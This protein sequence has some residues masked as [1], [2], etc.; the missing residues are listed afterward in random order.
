MK[1]DFFAAIGIFVRVV[2]SGSFTAAARQVNGSTAQISRAV[3][4]LERQLG[5]RLLNRTTRHI[6]MTES[7]ERYFK[8]AKTILADIEHA[9]AEA[10]NRL[11]KPYGKLR[12]HAMPSLGLRYLTSAMVQYQVSNPDVKIELTLSERFPNLIEDG[13]DVSLMATA[14]LPTSSYVSKAL[15]GNYSVLVASPDYVQRSGMPSTVTDLA[16]H[17]CLTLNAPNSAPEKWRLHGPDG[18]H[19]HLVQASPF[20]VNMPDAMRF[21]LLAGA[22]IGP[23]TLHSAIDDLRRGTLVRVLPEYRVNALTVYALYTSKRYLD[24]K[25]S[26]F[27]QHLHGI[28][29]PAFEPL[30]TLVA[31][32]R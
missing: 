29:L 3:A 17:S 28:A 32:N 25:V 16:A 30:D 24:A 15:G 31:A 12:V 10:R 20:Q 18:E 13:I 4:F 5:V 27:V 22:G 21:A 6:G 2:E 19:A 8:R 14:D 23:L 1:M 11:A 9:S 7:G 26:T